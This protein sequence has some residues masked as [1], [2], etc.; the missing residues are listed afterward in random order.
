MIKAEQEPEESAVPSEISN[1]NE[2][3]SVVKPF[4]SAQYARDIVA[5]VLNGEVDPLAAMTVVKRFEKV[6][7]TVLENEQFKSLAAAEAYKHLSGTQKTFSIYSATISRG[8]LSTKYDFSECGHPVLTQLYEIQKEVAEAIKLYENELKLLIPKD[9]SKIGEE[10]LGIP[11]GQKE[12]VVDR[13]PML[14]WEENQDQ[15]TVKAPKKMQ[16]LG[17]KYMKV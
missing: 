15:V 8:A 10:T 3:M 5:S 11:S 4:Q 6:A 16:A 9:D 7:K 12:I 1:V 2:L 17:I 14:K 13:M